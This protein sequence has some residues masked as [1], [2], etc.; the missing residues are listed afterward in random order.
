MRMLVFLLEEPSA[1]DLLAGILPRILPVEIESRYLVFEG[2][3]DLERRMERA[4]RA[5]ARPDSRFIVLR[6]QDSGDC[7]RIKAALQSRCMDAGRPD[8]IVRIACREL[9][10]FF[11]GNWAGVAQAFGIGKLAALDGKA[12]YRD[13]DAL[14]NPVLELRK[15]IPGYQKRDGARRIGHCLDLSNNRSRSL[16]ALVAAIRRAADL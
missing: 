15:Y 3:Q 7:R 5:W 6:D 16:M 9:E 13:P 11:L 8:A 1:R 12:I 10:S 14:G 2:K 4:L